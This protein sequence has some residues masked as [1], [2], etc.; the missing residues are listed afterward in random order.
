MPKIAMLEGWDAFPK[1]STKQGGSKMARR[2]RK[3]RKSGGKR[4]FARVARI[5]NKKKGKAARKACWRKH[6]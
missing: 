1:R 3:S 5:C 2:R 4:K 6:Y